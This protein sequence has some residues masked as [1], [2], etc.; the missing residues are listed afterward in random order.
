MILNRKM[1]KFI[2]RLDDDRSG[3]RLNSWNI[4]HDNRISNKNCERIE[5]KTIIR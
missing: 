4:T 3:L 1:R 2:G 5:K